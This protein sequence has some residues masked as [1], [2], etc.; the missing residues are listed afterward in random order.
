MRLAMGVI[1]VAFAIL[2]TLA[3]LTVV[4]L[5]LWALLVVLGIVIVK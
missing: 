2:G 4:E 5:L 3:I 1:L